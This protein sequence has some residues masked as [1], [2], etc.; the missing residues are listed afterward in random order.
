MIH[1]ELP[2]LPPS[3]NHA[4]T[5]VNNVQILRMD[6]RKYK[7]ET[8]TYITQRYPAELAQL[9]ANQPFWAAY[10]FVTPLL[11][12]KGYGKGGAKSRYKTFDTSNRIKLLEDCI[13]EVT[14]IDDSCCIGF[15]GKKEEGPREETHC[16]IWTEDAVPFT[17]FAAAMNL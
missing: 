17:E 4:Y 16:Y 8:V 7:K 6:G 11:Y 9:K 3:S 1:I 5:I 12:N 14:G 2:G 13:V 10:R 15:A